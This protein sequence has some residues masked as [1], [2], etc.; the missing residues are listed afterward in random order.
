[1][2]SE[3]Y[4]TMDL[5]ARVTE[6]CSTGQFPEALALIDHVI[7]THPELAG[8]FYI[9][10]ANVLGIAGQAEEGLKILQGLIAAGAWFSEPMLSFFPGL[11]AMEGLPGHAEAL[12]TCRQRHEEAQAAA[13]PELFTRFAESAVTP[14]PLVLALHGNMS[15]AAAA[16]RDWE[17][18]VQQGFFAGL[19]QSSLVSAPAVYVWNDWARAERELIA[20]YQSLV[21]DPAVDAGRTILGG[22]S[23]GGG[24]AGW[25]TLKGA[26]PVRGCILMGPY[27]PDME[28]LKREMEGARERGVRVYILVGDQDTECLPLAQELYSLLRQHEI[29]AELDVIPG[30]WHI[31]PQ[32]FGERFA[33]A[34]K[35]ILG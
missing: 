20:H 8:P 35:F 18:A 14:A 9:W 5:Q 27:I 6:L 30:L 21:A 34:A 31:F 2:E 28:A 23:M 32:D 24:V 4:L 33:R 11:R 3:G 1:M 26:V 12:A 15:S 29:P 25:L 7:A 10:K 22:F 17:P 13:K 16:T 19:A